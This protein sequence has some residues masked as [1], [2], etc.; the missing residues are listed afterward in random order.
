M[1]QNL[2][3]WIILALLLICFILVSTI[4]QLRKMA[5]PSRSVWYPNMVFFNFH[6]QIK[7][8]IM[9]TTA[10]V[11]QKFNVQWPA[12]MDKYNNEAQAENVSFSSD[13][14]EI[15]TIEPDPENGPYAAKVTTKQKV[16]STM[17]RI[18]GDAVLGE[19]EK[20]IEGLLTVEVL[21]G[22]A[23]GFGSPVVGTPVDN[24]ET[25]E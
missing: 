23:V 18:K 10:K 24:D 12:P 25:P 4:K 22:E 9:S 5:S 13:D 16:G 1:D 8:T 14:E 20:A 15:A 6:H 2:L 19:G 17:V 3:W 11:D 7:G 21:P